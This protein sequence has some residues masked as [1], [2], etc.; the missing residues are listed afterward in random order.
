MAKATAKKDG[1][2]TVSAPVQN[3]KV[4]K[5]VQLFLPETINEFSTFLTEVNGDALDKLD[6]DKLVHGYKL[7]IVVGIKA[8]ETRI[9]FFNE[10]CRRFKTYAK[11]RNGMDTL[12][13]A[14]TKHGLNYNTEWRAVDRATQRLLEDAQPPVLIAPNAEMVIKKKTSPLCGET[15]TVPKDDGVS[16]EILV[17]KTVDNLATSY[18]VKRPDLCSVSVW[19]KKQ[20]EEKAKQVRIDS[21]AANNA[22]LADLALKLIGLLVNA[23]KSDSPVAI[24]AVL[25]ETAEAAYAY[26]NLSA[27]QAKLIAVPKL[28]SRLAAQTK[29]QDK[30]TG[31][32]ATIDTMTATEKDLRTTVSNLRQ[33]ITQLKRDNKQLTATV[34]KLEKAAGKKPKSKKKPAIT[35][36]STPAQREFVVGRLTNPYPNDPHTH[37]VFLKSVFDRTR[38]AASSTGNEAECLKWIDTQPVAE[39]AAM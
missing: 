12:V 17:T 6:D 33:V 32:Q 39:A 35:R 4:D 16:K 38:E 3:G 27:D 28:V 30:V 7:A 9:V 15:V 11:K 21:K 20:E 31:L 26:E 25:R 24:L 36:V 19:K 23:P 22:V 13:D 5:N 10:M 37:G 8:V 2:H 1:T 34:T 18:K 29:L 14:F